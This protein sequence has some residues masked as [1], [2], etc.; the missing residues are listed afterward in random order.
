MPFTTDRP[1][2]PLVHEEQTQRA[3][4]AGAE[5][6]YA[7]EHFALIDGHAANDHAGKKCDA[8]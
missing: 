6:D 1:I 7:Y 5:P 8:P 2:Q 4:R 3:E